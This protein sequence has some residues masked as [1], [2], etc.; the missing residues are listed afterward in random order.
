MFCA[1]S[2]VLPLL[3]LLSGCDVPVPLPQ[4]H[5]AS[6]ALRTCA[7]KSGKVSTIDAAVERLNA[8]PMPVDAPCFVATVPRPLSLVST[9][10]IASAQPA[11]GRTN[12]RIFLML[13][14]LVVSVVPAGDGAKLLEF[15]E[16]MTPTRTLKGE[17]EVPVL[18]PLPRQAPY[19]HALFSRPA[20]TCA[21]CHRG[22]EPHPTIPDGYVSVAFKPQ[23]RTDVK[24]AELRAEHEA[25]VVAGDEEG[26]CA[27]F[28]ALFDFG[29]VRDGAFAAD[30]ETFVQ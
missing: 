27:M 26:R 21:L 8:L 13:E 16:W 18:A 12:P 2:R 29:D 3:V 5:R 20:T 7:Q 28:H 24:V 15:G 6:E 11:Q 17:L 10:G 23:P 4:A 1:V 22:E 25:C 30:V 14:G 9:T 19:E